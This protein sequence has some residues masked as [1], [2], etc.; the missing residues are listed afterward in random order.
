MFKINFRLFLMLVISFTIINSAL[1]INNASCAGKKINKNEPQQFEFSAK[2]GFK[3]SSKLYLPK[4]SSAKNKVPPVIFLHSL[5]ESSTSWSK[6]PETVSKDLKIAAITVDLRGHGKSYKDKNGN[7]KYWPYFKQKDFEIM[8]DDIL[9]LF[10]F[11][12]E[13]YPEINTNKAVLVG[14]GF[15]SSVATIAASKKNSVIKS[16]IMISP[17]NGSKGIDIRLPLINYGNKPVLFIVSQKDIASINSIKELEKCALGEKKLQTY[18]H[19]GQGTNLLK[20]Q[21]D[22]KKII[23]EWIKNNLI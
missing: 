5:G 9:A 13:E 2:D 7:R 14:A 21:P 16:V 20:L 8:P 17:E 23:E 12:K 3:I 22:A 15:G 1:L 19:G 11:L 10:N 18:P 4:G 6:L